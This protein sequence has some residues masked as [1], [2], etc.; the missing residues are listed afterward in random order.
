MGSDF[1]GGT[2]GF[3]M[4]V[5]HGRDLEISTIVEC[6]VVVGV[7]H[8]HKSRPKNYG[9][10]SDLARPESRSNSSILAWRVV[11]STVCK[12]RRTLVQVSDKNSLPC[13]E[14]R[15]TESAANSLNRGYV[16]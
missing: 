1:E 11:M 2:Y 5:A 4:A 16:D 13:S 7:V 15:P 3:E 6:T 8:R 10:C 12:W 9:Q 14:Q